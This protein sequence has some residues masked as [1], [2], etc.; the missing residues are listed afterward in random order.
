M[1]SKINISHL[2]SNIKEHLVDPE[3]FQ[4]FIDN[5]AISTTEPNIIEFQPR[6]GY[7][8][9]T[10][11][12]VGHNFSEKRT[13]NFVE[14]G[15]KPAH[16][17]ESSSNRLLVLTDPFTENGL[18]KV[19]VGNSTAVGP[20][21]FEKLPWP[22]PGSEKDG[23][24]YSFYGRESG[25]GIPS[26]GNIPATGTVKVLVVPS[27]PTDLTPTNLTTARQDIVDIF[28]NVTNFYDQVSYGTLNIDV[29]VIDFIPLLNNSAHY[30]RTNGSS[31]YPNID[32]A[33]LGQLMAE[34]AKGAVDDNL[35]ID[36]YD[37]MAAIVYLPGLGVRAWGGWSQ[38]NFAYDD[39]SGTNINITANHS[40]NLI[41]ARHDADWGRIAHEIGHNL[42]EGGLVLGE[43]V[44]A[45]DLVDPTTAT[46]TS[47]DM[48]GNHDS[49]PM[50]SGFYMHQLGYYDNSNI[51]DLQ[52]DR[53][54]FPRPGDTPGSNEY[55]L[56]AHGLS[57][58]TVSNRYHLIRIKISN[59]L[60]YF[61]EVR[62][63]PETSSTN[64]Q[65]FDE[66][67]PLPLGTT[68]T[69]GIIVTKAI[70]DVV[71]N[72]QQMRIITL[73][74]D[75]KVMLKNDVAIDPLRGLKITVV[76]DEVDTSP[77]VCKVKVEWAQEIADTP[78]GNFDLRIEP[79]NEKYE[80]KDI[81][82][83]RIPFGTYDF[84]DNSGNPTG[85]GDEPRPLEINR[86]WARVHND[87]SIDATKV[88]LTYYAVTPPGV[89]DNGTW[90]PL[91]TDEIALVPKNDSIENYVNWVPRV[92]EH[93]CLKVAIEQQLG[94]VTG[95]NNFAQENVF[96]FQPPSSIPE[97]V[98]LKMSVR[99]PLKEKTLIRI[100]LQGVP[101]G[102]HVYFP[103]RWI[104]L[105]PLE[106]KIFEL[107]VVP[108]TD[109]RDL[110][111]KEANIS[112]FGTV[113]RYYTKNLDM[114]GVPGSWMAPI[115]GILTKV[116][117]KHRSKIHIEDDKEQ[118]TQSI[119]AV[120]GHVTPH[121]GD[122]KL[123]VDLTFPNGKIEAMIVKT[124]NQGTFQAAF[125]LRDNV[126]KDDESPIQNDSVY[127]IQAHIFNAT[128][129]A[130]NNSNIVRFYR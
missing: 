73:L 14:V 54:P 102:F 47:F 103:H 10:M 49:H 130:P 32:N 35:N 40:L 36:N 94:E 93:T 122:Q 104:W 121:I 96:T 63:R 125:K 91:K 16:V 57:Q 1:S 95:G 41:A 65:I 13:E 9:T 5:H 71:N 70:T 120:K 56:V 6:K 27:Y 34:S 64:T 117:P 33:V 60:Y 21:N 124:N 17:V 2:V 100:G 67:I 50:F 80:T 28:E 81:W 86:F 83:D 106:E 19:T 18:V 111:V 51:L 45:S 128:H 43:D 129:L 48:M 84:T 4:Q 99:N 31:G 20:G 110:K 61:I 72:N 109:I 37:L 79:W 113:A 123:R 119:L 53:N 44:Y 8:G 77:L 114:T 62:Q 127:E 22:K 52:W 101:Q 92:G 46:A 82:I 29:D 116:L 108:T 3:K 68:K 12:I 98:S 115:G 42:V 38:N 97:P 66:N 107:L 85:N 55:E 118:T 24:P 105:E 26:T 69:G 89:G 78:N 39:G 25:N 75:P 11:V 87:G 76:E 7:S 126:K 88:L 112:V 30:H 59:G 23:P 58:N 74:H 90:T 15:G